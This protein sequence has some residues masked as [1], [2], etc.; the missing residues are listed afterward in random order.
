MK[1]LFY[2]LI[3]LILVVA[4]GCSDPSTHDVTGK[5]TMGGKPYNRL[6]VYMRP[7]SGKA[8]KF[9]TGV[10]STDSD[11]NL[12]FGSNVGGLAA[13]TYRVTFSLRVTPKNKSLKK[14]AKGDED[15]G[16]PEYQVEAVPSPYDDVTS[17]DSSP[18]EFEV[19][20]SGDNRFEFD[21]PTN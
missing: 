5:V 15:R 18:V 17:A 7:V 12:A 2:L 21:I 10:G 1:N 9:T 3:G 14:D 4:T 16:G 6:I 19:S 13:G 8:D 11:G 20:S